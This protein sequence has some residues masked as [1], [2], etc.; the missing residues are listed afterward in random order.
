MAGNI[1]AFQRRKFAFDNF[2]VTTWP[3]NGLALVAPADIVACFLPLLIEKLSVKK[4]SEQI[5]MKILKEIA[6][7]SHLSKKIWLNN[8][9]CSMHGPYSNCSLSIWTSRET[10]N[11]ATVAVA[12]CSGWTPAGA[13]ETDPAAWHPAIPDVTA[14]REEDAVFRRPL[15]TTT[16]THI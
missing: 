8:K 11:E 3:K 2:S 12:I 16:T 15:S 14:V 5:K 1:W 13:S 10:W 9:G 7:E 6:K 4:P